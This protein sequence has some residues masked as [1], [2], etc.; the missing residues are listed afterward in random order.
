MMRVLRQL[1]S[2]IGILSSL[3]I[4]PL[5]TTGLLIQHREYFDL[6]NKYVSRRFVP[7][8]YRPNDGPGGVRSDIFVTDIHSGRIIGRMGALA[9]DMLT[10][11]RILM[12]ISGAAI[13][14]SRYRKAARNGR[15][16]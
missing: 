13:F 10:L 11:A 8:S 7:R 9:V 3:N 15:I 4:L 1:H 6:E 12:V 2:L 16:E 5:I 14:G